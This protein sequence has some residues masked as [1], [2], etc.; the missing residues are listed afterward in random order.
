MRRREFIA[1]L[2][3]AA[4]WPVA[5]RAQ[6]GDRVRR[7]GVLMGYGEGDPEGRA[8]I[9]GFTQRLSEL[10]W[11]EGRNLRM[12]LRWAAADV[13]RMR[14]IG[15]ELV[16][17]QPEVIV[18]H[19]TSVTAALQRETRTIPIVFSNVADPSGFVEGLPHPGGNITGF[20]M[21]Q[22]LPDALRDLSPLSLGAVSRS[23]QC[24]ACCSALTRTIGGA[25]G[26][27]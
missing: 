12:D 3:V 10:G 26:G 7:I 21:H 8:Y 11:I 13:N 6:Q 2:G 16:G 25:R 1:G 24:V 9:S 19:T 23:A 22:T 27:K 4:A 5:A 20:L 15:K 14:A 17:L 18:A